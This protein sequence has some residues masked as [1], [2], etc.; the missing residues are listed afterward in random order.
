MSETM[1]TKACPHCD[2]AVGDCFWVDYCGAYV[3]QECGHHLGLARCYCGWSI[4]D[5][6]RGREEL[7]DMGE[8]IDPEEW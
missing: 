4:T 2:P 3:C 8:T 7:T 1:G 6:G 5:P